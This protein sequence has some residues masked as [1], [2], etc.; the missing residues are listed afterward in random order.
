LN[1]HEHY[2]EL[3]AVASS[4]QA[5]EVELADLRLHLET[6]PS[7]RSLAYDFTEIGAQ[8]LSVLAAERQRRQIP[9]GMMSRFVARARS[10]GIEISRA[11]GSR[12]MPKRNRFAIFAAVGIVAA[13]TLIVSFVTFI[14]PRPSSSAG[15][16]GPANQAS[17]AVSSTTSQPGQVSDSR[18]REQLASARAQL[19]SLDAKIKAQ[20]GELASVNKDKDAL[21]SHLAEAEQG[22]GA[23]RSE[24]AKQEARIAQLEAELEK[25]GSE[26]NASEVALALKDIELRELRKQ[27]ADQTEALSQQQEV[28]PKAGDVREL[29]VARNLH[30]IDVHDRDGDGK[31]QRAFGRIFYTEGKSLIFYAYDLADP[32]K[33]DAKVSFHV[34]GERLGT[35]KPIRSLGIFHND[36]VSDGRWVLTFDDPHVLAQINS[37]FVTVES[38]RKAMREPGGRRILFAFLGD[39]P[40]HP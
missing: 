14:R 13:L 10:E 39:K 35:E 37:V 15:N 20:A 40:N 21:N 8:G 9:L 27:V 33:V 30:I 31:S 38:S 24:R 7:C 29:V 6:C 17:A 22:N 11:P 16:R 26:K 28:T 12:K 3:C 32:R 19:R 25:S 2:E 34:W 5:S 4:G 23:F 18:L 36:D 1:T